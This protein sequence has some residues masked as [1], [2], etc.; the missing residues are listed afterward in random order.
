[1]CMRVYKNMLLL[2][3]ER[4]TNCLLPS[5]VNKTAIKCMFNRI[6]FAIDGVEPFKENV[7]LWFCDCDLV[8]FIHSA[9][10]LTFAYSCL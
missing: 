3:L 7:Q 10:K 4:W 8:K 1:M 9:L 5:F 6:L 2:V